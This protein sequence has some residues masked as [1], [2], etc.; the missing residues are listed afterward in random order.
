[1]KF[2]PSS[3]GKGGGLEERERERNK[4]GS[5]GEDFQEVPQRNSVR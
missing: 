5:R 4:E 3:P 1:M 2:C